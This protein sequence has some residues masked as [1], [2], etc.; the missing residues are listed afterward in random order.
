M[1]SKETKQRMR[2]KRKRRRNRRILLATLLILLIPIGIFATTF[3]LKAV[4]TGEKIHFDLGR[5]GS[6]RRNEAVEAKAQ[7]PMSFLLLGVDNREGEDDAGRSDSMIV[8]TV[9]PKQKSTKMLSIP[10]DLRV[11]VPGDSEYSKINSAYSKGGPKLA[12][13]TV[14]ELFNIPID[15]FVQVNFEGFVEIVDALGGIDVNNKFKFTDNGYTFEAGPLHLN[16]EEAL[17]Y[18]RMRHQDPLGDYGRQERQKEVVAQIIE[19]GASF[20]SLTNFSEIFEAL[21][22]N[23]KTDLKVSEMWDIKNNY[24]EAAGNIESLSV[25]ATSK[26][27]NGEWFEIMADE[28]QARITNDLRTH[29]E[30]PVESTS[31]DTKDSTTNEENTNSSKTEE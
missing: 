14:E 3:F 5:D 21:G 2:Q 13:E 1:N 22:N 18:V 19:Q 17:T 26:K 16:G 20:K 25:E 15:H 12:I 27:I 29:L 6:S 10:R 30:L 9:N 28:E 23:V 8:V 4:E 31:S 7:D 11:Q 24:T